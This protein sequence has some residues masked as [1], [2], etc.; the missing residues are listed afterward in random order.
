MTTDAVVL[1]TGLLSLSCLVGRAG[2]GARA[3]SR[4]V[5]GENTQAGL[6]SQLTDNNN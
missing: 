3:D 4:G 1:I 6:R 2:A 5:G